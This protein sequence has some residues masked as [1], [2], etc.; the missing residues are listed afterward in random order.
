MACEHDGNCFSGCCSL[1]VSGDS[2]RCMPLVNGGLC[3][4]AIDVV[5]KFQEL[6]QE[7]IAVLEMEVETQVDADEDELDSPLHFVDHK[8][9]TFEDVEDHPIIEKTEQYVDEDDY[10]DAEHLIPEKREHYDHDHPVAES[11]HYIPSKSEHR[12]HD[13]HGL[14]RELWSPDFHGHEAHIDESLPVYAHHYGHADG[15]DEALLESEFEHE[16]RGLHPK[17]PSHDDPRLKIPKGKASAA[18][19][20]VVV[21]KEPEDWEDSDDSPKYGQAY[22]HDRKQAIRGERESAGLAPKQPT[23]ERRTQV[24]H[25]TAPLTERRRPCSAYGNTNRCDGMSCEVDDDCA[26]SCCGQL[27]KDGSLQCHSLIEGSFC[28][29]ALAPL[30]DYSLYSDEDH[31]KSDRRRNAIVDPSSQAPSYRGQDGCKVHGTDDQCDGQPCVEDGD[32]HSGCCGHFVSFSLRRCLPL[33]EDAL[34]PRFLE[35]SFTSPIPARLPPIESTIKDMYMIQDRVH[36]LQ[37]V[38]DPDSLPVRTDILFCRAYGNS[39]LCDGFTCDEGKECSS[40]CCGTFGSL[41][42]N[43]CQPLVENVCPAPGFTYGPMGDIYKVDD[44]EHQASPESTT[45]SSKPEKLAA[46]STETQPEAD[47]KKASAFWFGV[48]IGAAIFVAVVTIIALLCCFCKKRTSAVATYE[49]M[50]Q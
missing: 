50:P 40:G 22:E 23:K 28:P 20:H 18:H 31:D 32:C 9:E 47:Q 39:K 6:E 25:P 29:R 5:E 27:T 42:D 38:M 11:D 19:D 1:F 36:R 45:A 49:A 41:K 43:Y 37:E 14:P 3:P 33:T 46:T 21:P 15:I 13:V 48:A 4:I 8:E 30:V 12:A 26:S 17:E 16:S 24:P 2:M 35:P 10:E 44:P 34:C 7:E